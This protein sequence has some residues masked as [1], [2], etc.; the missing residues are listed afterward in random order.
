[1]DMSRHVLRMCRS[2]LFWGLHRANDHRQIFLYVVENIYNLVTDESNKI[3]EHYFNFDDLILTTEL[4]ERLNYIIEELR[5]I[6]ILGAYGI[7]PK[8]KILFCGPPG[9]GKTLSSKVMSSVMNYPLVYIRF[10]SIVSSFL[11]SK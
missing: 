5:Y 4:K 1:M 7:R 2:V 3:K 6:E 8:Q 10:D 11:W 9:T